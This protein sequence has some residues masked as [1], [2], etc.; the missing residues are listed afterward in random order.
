MN[1]NVAD[2][3]DDVEAIMEVITQQTGQKKVMM[4]GTSSGALRAALY[5]QRHPE[6]VSKL[7]L[8]AFV[9]T[10]EGSPTLAERKKGLAQYRANNRR[11]IDRQSVERIFTVADEALVRTHWDVARARPSMSAVSGASNGR[12]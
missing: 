9:W 12:W 3:A 2:G 8:D 4:Q 6:R 5:A 1:A 11:P 7:I 10:G